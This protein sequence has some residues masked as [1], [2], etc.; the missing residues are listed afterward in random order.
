MDIYLKYILTTIGII[1]VVL[2]VWWLYRINALIENFLKMGS[3]I[4][5]GKAI[6]KIRIPFIFE[7]EALKGSYKGREVIV[8][9]IYSGLQ[10]EFLP[11]PFI[12]MRLI[13]SLGYN[14]NRLPNYA[15]ISNNFLVY[16]IKL[17][18]PWGVFDKTYPQVFNKNYLVIALEKLLATSEDVE[19]GRRVKDV[20]K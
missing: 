4:L 18:L 3:E 1:F 5:E 17:S 10:G 15:G 19:R 8:G 12:Q 14:T 2:V 7:K 6:T 11:L 9:V 16:K 20:F 13:E